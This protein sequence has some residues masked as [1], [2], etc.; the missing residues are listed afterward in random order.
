[1]PPS[2]GDHLFPPAVLIPQSLSSRRLA[3]KGLVAR[4][5]NAVATKRLVSGITIHQRVDRRGQSIGDDS[6]MQI[7]TGGLISGNHQRHAIVL[8]ETRSDLSTYPHNRRAAIGANPFEN[9]P[10]PR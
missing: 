6:L 1:V 3:P 9:V 8:P 10:A 7:H 5:D 2:T 4:R